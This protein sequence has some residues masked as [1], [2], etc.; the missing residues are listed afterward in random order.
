MGQKGETP[1]MASC[2]FEM[3]S[4]AVCRNGQKINTKD[5]ADYIK[6]EGKYA[7]MKVREANY[8]EK[9]LYKTSGNLP[10]WAGDSSNEFWKAAEKNRRV[11]GNAYR[12]F[13]IGLQNELTLEQNI[14]C[15]EAFLKTSGI[16]DNHVYT[17]AV[18]DKIAAFA[19]EGDHNLHAHIM[20]NERKLEKDRP[21]DRDTFFKRYTVQ[22]STGKV[23]GGYAVAPHW[24]KKV[25]FIVLEKNGKE[26]S[27]I[28]LKKL[29]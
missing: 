5:H 24:D 6:R 13:R 3:A 25:R 28:S 27:M 22:P 17:Y 4:H 14:E 7:H 26:S 20:F 15:I 1:A 21:L 10:E 2:H 29:N 11:K 18:H 23:T 16:T 9:L 19:T 8:K 12:E